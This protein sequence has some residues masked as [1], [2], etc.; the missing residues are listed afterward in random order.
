MD[1]K[2][3]TEWVLTDNI[4]GKYYRYRKMIVEEIY[5]DEKKQYVVEVIY[6]HG[7]YVSIDVF[8]D[9]STNE[10]RLAIFDTIEEAREHILNSRQLTKRS[11]VE[12]YVR[13]SKKD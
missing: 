9:P 12:A 8:H 2:V 6:P 1:K 11:M 4:N 5:D 13:V 3:E 10:D 7:G